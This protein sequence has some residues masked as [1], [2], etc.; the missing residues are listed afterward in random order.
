MYISEIVI[1]N[2]NI[3]AFYDIIFTIRFSWKYYDNIAR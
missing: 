1:N 2:F 3:N